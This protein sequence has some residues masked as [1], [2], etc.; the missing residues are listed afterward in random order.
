[1]RILFDSKQTQYKDPFGTLVPNQNCT[2]N[3]HVPSTVQA[4]K[5]ECIINHEHGALAQIVAMDYKKKDGP[6]DIF[7]GSFS[8]SVGAIAVA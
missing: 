6:Y 7:T 5:V 4:T 3:I 8:F 1:M 2:L